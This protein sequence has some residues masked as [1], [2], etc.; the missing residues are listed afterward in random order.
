MIDALVKFQP[1]LFNCMV[2]Q[3]PGIIIGGGEAI[4]GAYQ[5]GETGGG[6]DN[7]IEGIIRIGI[8]R[9]GVGIGMAGEAVEEDSQGVNLARETIGRAA[10][11]VVPFDGG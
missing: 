2:K 9:I 1:I 3:D 4:L 8:E 7:D 6:G 10:G 11:E 5:G